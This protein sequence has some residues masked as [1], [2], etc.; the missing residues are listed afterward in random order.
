MIRFRTFFLNGINLNLFYNL[1]NELS[2]KN[3]VFVAFI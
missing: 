2:N 1:N 3:N